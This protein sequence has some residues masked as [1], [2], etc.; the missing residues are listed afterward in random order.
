MTPASCHVRNLERDGRNLHHSKLMNFCH[1]CVLQQ[2]VA[3]LGAA[4]ELP[5][6]PCFAAPPTALWKPSGHRQELP[7]KLVVVEERW[8]DQKCTHLSRQDYSSW[9]RAEGICKPPFPQTQ[10]WRGLAAGRAPG[11]TCGHFNFGFGGEGCEANAS[12]SCRCYHATL[13][14]RH[15]C[16][17]FLS[18]H[19]L[20]Y[21]CLAAFRCYRA[22]MSA[23]ISA[24]VRAC[25][26]LQQDT[27]SYDDV[28]VYG[29]TGHP[30]D[31][32]GTTAG[33][34]TGP[35]RDNPRDRTG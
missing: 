34:P 3:P 33:Q 19:R 7:P 25:V 28:R 8:A 6:G 11:T 35:P 24:C 22:C 16:G 4:P 14:C 26:C 5:G 15:G 32:R 13:S 1:G 12:C 27:Q 23:R 10:S 29:T 17:H 9:N 18:G 31:H 20:G 21:M 30:E 2:R